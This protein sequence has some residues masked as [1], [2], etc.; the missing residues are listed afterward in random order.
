MVLTSLIVMAHLWIVEEDNG[1]WNHCLQ[2]TDNEGRD[3]L[4]SYT[5]DSPLGEANE[6]FPVTIEKLDCSQIVPPGHRREYRQ[7]PAGGFLC[8]ATGVFRQYQRGE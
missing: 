1:K 6:K 5:G 4:I 3:L 2:A 8:E 7:Y